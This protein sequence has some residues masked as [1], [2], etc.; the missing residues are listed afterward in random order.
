[1]FGSPGI[2]KYR[3]LLWVCLTG[4]I[5]TFLIGVVSANLQI[6]GNETAM[7][8]YENGTMTTEWAVDFNASPLEGYPPLCT[9]FT[10]DGPLGD[11]YWDFG[12]G[13]TSNARD[14]VHCYQKKGS[15][16]VKL[17]YFVGQ[18]SG[19]VNKESFITVK[20][21]APLVDYTGEPVNGTAP[22]TVQFSIAGNPTTI[23][24][25]FD[26]GEESK[27]QNPRHQYQHSGY[28]SPTLTYCASGVCDKISKYNYIEVSSGEE[29]NFTAEK[30]EGTAPLSTKFIATGPAETFSWDFGDGTTSYE[31]DPGHYYTQPG[32][33][34]V[35]LSYSIDGASYTLTKTDYIHARS[36]YAPEF[37]GSPLRGIAPLCVD[38]DMTNQPQSWLWMFGDNTT[39]PDAHGSHC[40]GFSGKYDVGVH[41]CYNGYCDDVIKPGFVTVDSPRIFTERGANEATVKFRTDAGEGLTYIWEF[42]DGT[43]SESAGPTHTYEDP[44]EYN[45][46]L[47]ILGTCSCTA[48]A[49]VMVSVNTKKPLDFS[50]TPLEGCAPHS[51]QFTPSSPTDKQK[52]DFGD[53][54]TSTDRNPFHTYQFAGTY[55]VTLEN[56]SPDREENV[57]KPDC[58]TVH[59][60]PRPSFSMNP[61]SGIAPAT[62]TFTDTTSGYESKRSWDF[63]DGVSG[64]EARMD[65]QYTQA[66][67]YNVSL[68]VW[69]EGDCHNTVT[70]DL[71]IASPDVVKYDL[72][73]L[74]RR[75]TA[76]LSTSFKITGSPYQWTIDFGDGETTSEQNP[77]HTYTTPG[78]YS[79]KFHACDAGGCEDIVKP[80]YVL[81]IPDSYQNLTLSRGWN[82]ISVPFSLEPGKDTMNIFASVDTASHS[83]YSWDSGT[84]QWKRLV[85]DTQLDPLTAVWIYA[86]K[87]A[88]VSLPLAT[89]GPE[90]NLTRSLSTGWNLVSFPGISATDPE[91]VLGDLNWSYAL[92]FDAKSQQYN[93]PIK[94][95]EETGDQMLDPRQGYWL[96]MEKPGVLITQ[97]I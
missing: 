15:Y 90:S 96:Y 49:T 94:K 5:L 69:G 91:E 78:V 67:V 70:H 58:I 31:Q 22:L 61:T 34:T 13:T 35:T 89:A 56:G 64:T 53:G 19:E 85:K 30:R 23:L 66:G 52:W 12:D 21:P 80:D 24:W 86:A 17:K 76:P 72:S 36:R 55:T 93:A 1:M 81:V 77:F 68:M 46:T 87:P 28:Y 59:E 20:D 51:V 65:H 26:D 32:N 44:G 97:A 7:A 40:Y 83:V 45:V 25:S 10:V 38:L 37:N 18:I 54:E 92:G 9:K 14:P 60:I 63:G 57:T 47:S 6:K 84:E 73:G 11:Y 43:S 75:G 33:Y 29:V 27:E 79:P 74:P 50:A 16:W 42:G 41:Y 2:K 4:M 3:S 82:L 62:I 8:Q 88:E 71:Q 39:S 95:G 48:R